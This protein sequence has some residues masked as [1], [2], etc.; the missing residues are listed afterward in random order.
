M[1]KKQYSASKSFQRD[2]VRQCKWV[3]SKKNRKRFGGIPFSA[4]STRSCLEKCKEK[5]Q[6]TSFRPFWLSTEYRKKKRKK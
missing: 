1:P 5:L 4:S 2:I 3:C 6:T